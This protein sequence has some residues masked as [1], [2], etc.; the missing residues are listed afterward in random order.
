MAASQSYAND[1]QAVAVIKELAKQS[2]SDVQIFVNRSD[3]PGG[4]TLGSITSSVL[5]MRTIDI[6]VPIL[7]MHSARELMGV[8]DQENIEKLL[9]CFFT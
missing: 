8:K 2:Q 9:T 5:P 3:M 1:A 4:S 7:A 6:G